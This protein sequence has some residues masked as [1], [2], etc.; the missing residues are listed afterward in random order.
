[1]G[2]IHYRIHSILIF[3]LLVTSKVLVAQPR[4]CEFTAGWIFA[5]PMFFSKQEGGLDFELA[6]L[7]FS[8]V[9]C[10]IVFENIPWARQIE[11]VKKKQ[12]L[13]VLPTV[14][15]AER[16]KFGLF[17][18]AYRSVDRYIWVHQDSP[19]KASNPDQFYAQLPNLK[20]GMVRG[21]TFN[22]R[23]DQSVKAMQMLLFMVNNEKQAVE[24]LVSQR[25][26]VMATSDYEMQY[27][28][29]HEQKNSVRK[30]DFLF[31][32]SSRHFFLPQSAE[33]EHLQSLIDHAIASVI[34]TEAYR[35]ILAKYGYQNAG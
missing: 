14:K 12:K 34:Q 30:L 19:I 3:C 16:M 32:H 10:H 5:P 17:S 20:F 23:F 27:N 25:I 29:S 4:S 22:E 24:M 21:Y 1:M 35:K 8:K 26:D 11:M 31:D 33:G 13:V 9:D 18:S 6:N 2:Y 28:L 7:I 15:T